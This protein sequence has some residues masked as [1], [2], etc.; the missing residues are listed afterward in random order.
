M[1][2]A[3]VAGFRLIGGNAV[4]IA[5]AVVFAVLLI[6]NTGNNAG[7]VVFD[8][9]GEALAAMIAVAACV[10]RA[11][12]VRSAGESLL[13]A[14][15]D[16][17]AWMLI[18]AGCASWAL[19][20]SH[21]TAY[22]LVKHAEPVAPSIPDIGFLASPILVIAGLLA[23]VA[24]AAGRLSQIRGVVE[25]LLI[26]AGAFL[27]SWVLLIE[28][29]ANQSSGHTMEQVVL[30]AYPALDAIALAAILFAWLRRRNDIPPGLGF[31]ALGIASIAVA[32]SAFWHVTTTRNDFSGLTP[33]GASW[34]TGFVLVALA[35]RSVKPSRG[36]KPGALPGRL[37]A[38]IPIVPATLG[39]IAMLLAPV[40]AGGIDPT[41]PL[42]II[43]ASIVVL[44]MLLQLIA[45][46]ENGA[47][48]VDLESRVE[49]RTAELTKA[50]RYFR[51]LVQNS[52]DIVVVIGRGSEIEYVSDSARDIFGFAPQALVGVQLSQLSSAGTAD[53]IAAFEQARLR[54]S[55]P[56]AFKWELKDPSGQPRIAE[57][58][59]INLIDDPAVGG[60]VMNTRDATDRIA[61]ERQ[62]SHKALHD[63]VT[64]V[65][66]RALLGD[67]AERALERSRRSN[68]PTTCVMINIDRLSRIND[69]L[70]HDAGDR[71]LAGVAHRLEALMGIDGT[72]ARV[73]AN[74]FA[75]LADKVS[76]TRD[77]IDL[78]DELR[79]AI[80]EPLQLNGQEQDVNVTATIALAVSGPET[81]DSVQL[82]RNAETALQVARAGDRGITSV[83]D[84]EMHERA[85]RRLML[86]ADLRDALKR[87]ELELFY[88]PTFKVT[89]RKLTGFEALLRWRHPKLGLVPPDDFIP[90]AE[91]SGLIVPIG[92][93]VLDEAIRQL[94][95]WDA[96]I[97]IHRL[98]MSINVS[99]VQLG[100]ESLVD[101]VRSALRK[102]EISPERIVLEL[103]ESAHLEE[104][105]QGVET[106]RAIS[107]LGVHIAV[108]DFGTGYASF[109]YLQRLPLDILKIDRSYVMNM[110]PGDENHEL[111][112]G[113]VALANSLSLITVAEGVE[114]PEHLA[115]LAE[116]GCDIAQGYLLGKP[117]PADAAGDVVAAH[118][119]PA[120]RKSPW[121]AVPATA[122]AA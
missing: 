107:K 122:R 103:T 68:A 4:L 42:M 105:G 47:L 37:L 52:T 48:M 5:S 46:H 22:Y 75:V 29:T 71:V 119:T 26:A 94:A 79:A 41:R 67:R 1:H 57:S 101:D 55:E 74:E 89:D 51:A 63:D 44:A 19:A 14:R 95:E 12:R 93:W 36:V 43:L 2:P 114:R 100:C 76:C 17:Y 30:L 62:L 90:F 84:P 3:R 92:R 111:I 61:L 65:A 34:V 6:L 116:I 118:L 110:Q 106:L 20:Q 108:D 59:I 88:Q 98:R 27:L 13:T 99:P 113:M 31:L 121:P 33:I 83:F 25:G 97:P 53:L 77:A 78:A 66:N 50:E 96:A 35:A 117:M 104:T 69:T 91:E 112:K 80:S 115:V 38:A 82:L 9:V 87:G 7:W 70:G 64:G 86:Q 54:P 72:V 16:S 60:F 73:G 102:G 81:T 45:I 32:D 28:P 39:V 120:V 109:S 49:S 18:A 21:W 23:L 85:S 15:R 11:R 58:T 8:D 40:F 56:V 10:M 24:T